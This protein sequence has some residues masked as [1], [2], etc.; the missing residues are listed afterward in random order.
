MIQGINLKLVF[1]L[2]NDGLVPIYI[3][4]IFY[5]LSINEVLSENGNSKINSII[6]PRQTLEI[7]SLRDIQRGSLLPTVNS[8]IN[9]QGVM[10]LKGNCIFSIIRIKHSNSM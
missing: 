9:K 5:E 7:V 1:E 6:N 10:D 3:P 4:D 2:S 8:V